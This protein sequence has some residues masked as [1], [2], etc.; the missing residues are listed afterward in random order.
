M[1]VLVAGAGPAGWAAAAACA[2]AGLDTVLVDPAP[3]AR[4]RATYGLWTEDCTVL[5]AGSR[6]VQAGARAVAMTEHRLD[7]TYAVL[8]NESVRTALTRPEIATVADGVTAAYTGPHGS[9]VALTSGRVLAAAVVIDA[10]GTRRVL[11]GGPVRAPRVEQSAFGVVLP[12]GAATPLV[13]P[14]A[15]LFMDWRPV[16]G[17]DPSTFLYGVPLPD[18]RVLLEE[19]SLARRPGMGLAEL[20]SRLLARLGAFGVPV[21]GGATERVRFPL[22][23]PVPRRRAGVVTF[24]AAAA[25]VHPATGYGVA[26]SFRLAP[27]LAEAISGGLGRD[28]GMAIRAARQALW[29][30]SARA[31]RVLRRRG[32]SVLLAL[33]PARLPQFFELFFRLPPDLQRTYLAGRDDIAGTARAMTA[34]FRAAEGPLRA[35]IAR[36]WAKPVNLGPFSVNNR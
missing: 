18:G 14:G 17:F 20:R 35:S 8:D 2:A 23:L 33:P 30:P 6:W 7:R 9:S 28:P 1:D 16:P 27:R 15:A 4:W 25:L 12:A 21:S 26:D 34:I 31:V 29:P 36:H 19:T 24:G 22:D 3:H 13:E 32:L 11:S 5:P 10:T